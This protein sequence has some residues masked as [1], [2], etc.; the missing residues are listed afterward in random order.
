MAASSMHLS[1]LR[2]WLLSSPPIEWGLSHLR[3]LLIGALREGPIPQHVAF[4][5]DGNRRFARNHR[6]EKVEGHNLG[7]EALA[8]ILEVCY[9]AGVKVVTVYAFSIE[10]FKRSKY[11][12][13]ALMDMARV[14]LAQ[15]SQ[16]GDLL[17]RYGASVRV[18]GRRDL[19]KPE[20]LEAID[21]AVELT[22][23]NGD[24]IL[25]ICFP[26]T[27]RD[28]MTTAIRNTVIEYSTPLD[29][30][31]L[32]LSNGQRRTFSETHIAESIQ[33][34]GGMVNGHG[35]DSSLLRPRGKRATK[36]SN[37][38]PDA[39]PL[40]TSTTST[41]HHSHV[42]EKV[43]IIPEAYTS[44]PPNTD[45]LI[46]LSPETITQQTLTDHMLT[47]GCPPLDLLVRTSGVERLSDFMLWQCHQNT[48][49]VFL[50]ILWPSFD[51]WT[52]LPVLWE[53]QWRVRKQGGQN[54]E[55][56]DSNEDE[57]SG[58]HNG[59]TNGVGS[60]YSPLAH[61]QRARSKDR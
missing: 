61:R 44:Y 3:E 8:K 4:V 54:G 57:F 42:A 37:D 51:L 31:Q 30:T 36:S 39:F 1:K 40:A 49:I 27:S 6:I 43:A 15:L 18:L 60:E 23:R 20:V 56:E 11:E 2:R 7:F 9:K 19:V 45:Q 14:K 50:D 26:Y 22:S 47:A 33:K 10:N 58:S 59:V 12:V 28:E 38:D 17:D 41:D 35:T 34:E 13:D 29:R 55:L 46:F 24:A 5:M 32:P 21:K 53:W 48:E 25:N 16:H 52:F